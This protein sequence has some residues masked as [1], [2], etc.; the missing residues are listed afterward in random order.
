LPHTNCLSH[1]AIQIHFAGGGGGGRGVLT[2]VEDELLGLR[3]RRG[4]C[5]GHGESRQCC[6]PHELMV[7]HQV[8]AHVLGTCVDCSLPGD[9]T[10]REWAQLTAVVVHHLLEVLPHGRT[11]ILVRS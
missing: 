7:L 4:G 1:S 8:P 3:R 10:I 9:A 5:G 11:S 6:L 2:E